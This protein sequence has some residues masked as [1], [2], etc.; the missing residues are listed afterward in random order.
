MSQIVAAVIKQHAV[1]ERLRA[2]QRRRLAR[3]DLLIELEHAFRITLRTVLLKGRHDLGLFAEETDD[4]F[5][6]T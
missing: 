4:L 2:F 5:I 3:T 6:G 1:D